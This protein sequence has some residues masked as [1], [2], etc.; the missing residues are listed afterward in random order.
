LHGNGAC[1][2]SQK[3][4]QD[5][6]EVK[7]SP[8]ENFLHEMYGG[9]VYYVN[10]KKKKEKISLSP[11]FALHYSLPLKKK[12]HGPFKENFWI[13]YIRKAH[14][15]KIP[16]WKLSC[17]K[18]RGFKIARFY[19]K[20]VKIRLQGDILEYIKD[21]SISRCINCNNRLK[22]LRKC[23]LEKDCRLKVSKSKN[24]TIKLVLQKFKSSHGKFLVLEAISGLI[25][26]KK[27]VFNK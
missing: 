13:Y 19:D 21:L 20:N 1:V 24:K 3:L 6:K 26:Q 4:S 27:L 2:A 14:F 11:P 7:I 22:E 25:E 23:F 15:T 16:S 17:T 8:V 18:Y 10:V 5:I 12:K 9:R